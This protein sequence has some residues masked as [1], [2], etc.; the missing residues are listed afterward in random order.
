MRRLELRVAIYRQMLSAARPR[1]KFAVGEFPPAKPVA[2]KN[3]RFLIGDGGGCR[4][5]V[6]AKSDI[7]QKWYAT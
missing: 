3:L 5:A 2:I 4:S 6:T 1:L 7:I